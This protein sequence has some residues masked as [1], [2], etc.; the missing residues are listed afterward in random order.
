[1]NNWYVSK[2]QTTKGPIV[3]ERLIE[4]I[5]KGEF[6]KGSIVWKKGMKTWEPIEIHFANQLTEVQGEIIQ[7]SRSENP[8]IPNITVI[9]PIPETSNYDPADNNAP[10]IS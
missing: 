2:S 3:E 4:R 7:E 6:K 5:K 8:T 10:T 9:Q 1:M